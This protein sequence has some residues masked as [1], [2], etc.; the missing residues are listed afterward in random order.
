MLTVS[1]QGTPGFCLQA[2]YKEMSIGRVVTSPDH[3][4][5]GLGKSIMEAS[6]AGCYEKFGK[7]AIRI[8]AQLYLLK[9]YQSLGF[10]EEG[11]PYDEDGIPHIGMIKHD[12]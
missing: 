6:I 8:S 2:S 5:K 1:W 11:L 7:S 12:K 4:G 10:T 3:R 9:F